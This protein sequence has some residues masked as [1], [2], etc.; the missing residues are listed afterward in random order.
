MQEKMDE[1]DDDM[2]QGCYTLQGLKVHQDT[3]RPGIYIVNGRKTLV[4]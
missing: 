2:R 1:F 3:L 4:R